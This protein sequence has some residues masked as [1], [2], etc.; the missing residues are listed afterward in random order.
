MIG[1]RGAI[2]LLRQIEAA[3]PPKSQ[4]GNSPH[5]WGTAEFS[6]DESGAKVFIFY[7]GGDLDYIEKW[8]DADG[9]EHDPWDWPDNDEAAIL[10]RAWRGVGELDR[11]QKEGLL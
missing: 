4:P 5:Y 3:N 9:T 6:I 1:R 2:A 8:V 10:I 7:D 11:W